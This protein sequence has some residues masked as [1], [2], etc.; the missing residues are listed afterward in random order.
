MNPGLA[1]LVLRRPRRE[2]RH[3][4]PRPARHPNRVPW[5]L[6]FAGDGM[7]PPPI[8]PLADIRRPDGCDCVD[9]GVFGH[10]DPC[11][12]AQRCTPSPS[13]AATVPGPDD[14]EALS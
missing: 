3:A 6:L 8:P 9:P 7:Q 5:S 12:R 14:D 11:P 13:S 2:P 4:A 10:T 1:W